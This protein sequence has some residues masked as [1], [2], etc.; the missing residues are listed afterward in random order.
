MTSQFC[1]TDQPISAIS[2]AFV[3]RSAALGP[4]ALPSFARIAIP[5]EMAAARKNENAPKNIRSGRWSGRR[6]DSMRRQIPA[7]SE[8]LPPSDP[9]LENSTRRRCRA[10]NGKDGRPTPGRPADARA[11]RAPSPSTATTR[12]SQGESIAWLVA[13]LRYA[14]AFQFGAITQ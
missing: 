4:L 1:A 10:G 7:R 14:V 5:C 6:A 3:P 13:L 12:G 2:L 11:S 9:A 8:F